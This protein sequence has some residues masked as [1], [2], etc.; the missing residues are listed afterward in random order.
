M[1]EAIERRVEREGLAERVTTMLGTADGSRLPPG[2]LDAVLIVD[3]YPRDGAAG[4]RCSAM[5]AQSLK[6]DGRIGIVDY[7]KD[8]GG[9][10]PAMDERVDP[11]QV[12]ARRA[13]G[14]ARAAQ[15]REVPPLSVHA[16]SFGRPR[17]NERAV[18]AFF[19]EYQRRVAAELRAAR[20]RRAAAASS[21]RWPTRRW[22]RRSRSA[23]CSSLLCA[24]LCGG[25]PRAP[26]PAAAAIELVHAS[27]LDPRRSAVDGRC[28]APARAAGESSRV[29]RG[30]AILAAFGLLN[31]AYGDARARATSRRSASR[32]SALLSDAVG[33]DG[34]DRRPGARSAG[35]R[36]AI[37]F[38][39]AR[40]HPS[41]QDRRAV[42]RRRGVRRDDRGR[43]RPNRSRA[44]AAYAKNLGLAFQI[45]D[46][47]LDVAGD[48]AEP[49]RPS[50]PTRARRR[51]SRSAASTARGSSR[52]SCARRRIARWRRSARRRIGCASCPRSW[53]R[54]GCRAG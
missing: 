16:R 1:I 45:V 41:R 21:G 23:P 31:L 32:M 43:R 42:R 19:T 37:S 7:K 13:G 15:A 26:V 48:P 3:A 8:G 39:D 9:P 11:E 44:L 29:R 53:R 24:E 10:G 30:D 17:R 2:A 34:P 28:A 51:S 22:R 18:P 6:P 47:L 14:R 52:R 20:A 12:I 25:T 5:S 33:P 35:D 4:R 46:D 40:A 54:D 36:S 27:S 50:A 38:R 49:A